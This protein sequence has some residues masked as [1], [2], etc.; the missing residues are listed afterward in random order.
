MGLAELHDL[1][2]AML[3]GQ[4]RLQEGRSVK[5]VQNVGEVAAVAGVVKLLQFSDCIVA[6][7]HHPLVQYRMLIRAGRMAGETWKTQKW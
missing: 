2:G 5:H 4:I 7:C 3:A 1:L 6:E